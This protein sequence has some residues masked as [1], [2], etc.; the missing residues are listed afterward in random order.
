M[1]AALNTR[2]LTIPCLKNW[3]SGIAGRCRSHHFP[4]FFG[5]LLIATLVYTSIGAVLNARHEAEK[6]GDYI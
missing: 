5:S 4:L 3:L 1:N 2:A 6:T